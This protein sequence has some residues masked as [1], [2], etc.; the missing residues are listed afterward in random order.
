MPRQPLLA[1]DLPEYIM[2]RLA[3][4]NIPGAAVAV[5]N[6]QETLL[7]QGFG[8]RDLEANLPVEA[9]TLFAIADTPQQALASF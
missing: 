7:A 4:W 2:P 3:A 5:V 1:Q 6:D 8:L 9:D